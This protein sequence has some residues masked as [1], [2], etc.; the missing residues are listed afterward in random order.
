M[1]KGYARI[2]Y[3]R[4]FV[5]LSP[6][7]VEKSLPESN[8]D[9]HPLRYRH[10][11][12]S[13]IWLSVYGLTDDIPGFRNRLGCSSSS[14]HFL[15]FS[16]SVQLKCF[17]HRTIGICEGKSQWILLAD[18]LLHGKGRLRHCTTENNPSDNHG[19]DFVPNDRIGTRWSITSSV[20]LV[21][22]LFNFAAAAICLFIRY[23]LQGQGRSQFG[24]ISSCSSVAFAGY[25]SITMRF[26]IAPMAP[27]MSIFHYGFES[28]IVNEVTYLTLTDRKYGLDI[29]FLELQS[30]ALSVSTPKHFGQM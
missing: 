12:S 30:S 9:A 28:L 3:L 17:R 4:Q 14:S 1:G 5:I 26:Q 10:P 27:D 6:E 7:D 20:H 15:D 18:Y 22:V 2:G 24:G 29:L 16:A 25:S 11:V 23:H 8:V 13:L 19:L 21:L